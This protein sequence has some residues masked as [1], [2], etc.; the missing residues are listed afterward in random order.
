MPTKNFF[1]LKE[2]IIDKTIKLSIYI[3]NLLHENTTIS[4]IHLVDA[5]E[6]SWKWQY[7]S[8]KGFGSSKNKIEVKEGQFKTPSV[9]YKLVSGR[10]GFDINL[11][12]AHAKIVYFLNCHTKHLERPVEE[13]KNDFTTMAKFYQKS[14]VPIS[15]NETYCTPPPPSGNFCQK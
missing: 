8:P 7:F 4:L 14:F 6:I 10:R 12:A 1:F 9:S 2:K 5:Q 3:K 13:K 15:R 11:L